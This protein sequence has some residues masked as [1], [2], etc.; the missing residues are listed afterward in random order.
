VLV[1]GHDWGAQV[2]WHLCLFRP[3]RVRAVV[4]LGIPYF[5]RGSRSISEAFAALGDGFYITQF[6]VVSSPSLLG[7]IERVTPLILILNL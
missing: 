7:S 6:Q 4:I 2:A 1:V 3:D 5:P